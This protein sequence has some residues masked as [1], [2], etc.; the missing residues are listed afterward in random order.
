MGMSSPSNDDSV[1][2]KIIAEYAQTWHHLHRYDEALPVASPNIK[3]STEVL[4]YSYAVEAIAELK[5]EL[6]SKNLATDLFGSQRDEMLKGILGNLEQTMDGKPLYQSPEEKAAHLLY[7]LV[8]DH[9]FSDGNKRIG[10]LLF[11]IY[12]ENEGIE[13]NFCSSALSWLTI[14]IAKS[15]PSEK[16]LII[17]IVVS[18]LTGHED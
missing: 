16:D 2:S 7:F 8:K 18:Q 14:H 13:Y 3:P 12:L 6:I 17:S 5:R 1:I 11:L 9:P 4:H 15:D 10:A